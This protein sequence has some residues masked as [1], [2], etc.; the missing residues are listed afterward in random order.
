MSLE[1]TGDQQ[2]AISLHDRNLVVLAAAGS[3]KTFVLV[4]RYLALLEAHQDW[5]LE[6]LVAITFTRKAARELRERVRQELQRYAHAAD[7][8]QRKLWQTH[9]AS[10]ESAQISTIHGLCAKILRISAAEAGI[11]P[12]FD[13]LEADEAVIE[14]EKEIED[15]LQR[16]AASNDPSL[17]LFAEY[18]RTQI[19]AALR[20]QVA[21]HDLQQ[22]PEDLLQHWQQAWNA[23]VL[24]Q[25]DAL[26][27][28]AAF[29]DAVKWQRDH[30][31]PSG[32][33]LG[34]IWVTCRPLLYKLDDSPEPARALELMSEL[35]STIRLNVGSAKNWGGKE[36]LAEAKDVLRDLRV[37]VHLALAVTGDGIT[38]LDHRAA[39]LLPHWQRMI[40][41]VQDAFRARKRDAN[42]L[43]FND[44]ERLT[45]DVL[46]KP[47]VRDRFHR[48]F[49]QVLVDEF[50]DTSPLQW[51][52]IRA[53]ANPRDPG[54]LFVV[55]DPRQSI[56]AFRGADVRVFDEA[57]RQILDGGG[58]EISL[59]HSFR[60]HQPLLDLLNTTFSKVLQRASSGPAAQYEVEFGEALEAQRQAA[61]G[62]HPALELMLLDCKDAELNADDGHRLM[63]L[64]LGLRLRALV[65]QQTPVYDREIG[66]TR[67]LDYGDVALLFQT[68][69]SMPFYEDAF[70][71]LALPYVTVGGRGFYGRQ[72]VLDLLNLLRFLHN[73]ND[74]LALASVLRSPLFALSD[75]ALL[76][77]RLMRYE[78]DSRPPLWDALQQPQGLPGDE[79]PRARAASDCLR[80]LAQ[81][82]GRLSVDDLLRAA[83]ERTGYLATLTGL[84]DG[85]RRRG[86]VEK[87]VEK[88]AESG[89][90]HFTDFEAILGEFNARE[91]REGEAALEADGALT[92]MT[93]HQAKGLEFPMVVLADAGRW[94]TPTNDSVLMRD[95]ESGLACKVF[96]M[97]QGKHQPTVA[98]QLATR[99][100]QQRELAERRRLFYVAATRAQDYL[101]VCGLLEDN[102]P[103]QSWLAWLLKALEIEDLSASGTR[104]VGR[105]QAN[106]R[107]L[108]V[109]SVLEPGVEPPRPS[110]VER[111]NLAAQNDEGPPALLR[112]LPTYP[113]RA[114]QQLTV[115]SISRHYERVEG[116]K[117][118]N[119]G[120]DRSS[121]VLGDA[122]HE[123]LRWWRPDT[124]PDADSMR[125]R[126]RSTIRA[127]G[128][129]NPSEIESLAGKALDLL[130][131][132]ELSPLCALMKEARELFRELPFIYQRRDYLIDG[133]LDLLMQDAAGH[134]TLVDFKTAWL[135]GGASLTAAR[136]HAQRYHMQLGIY[137]EAVCQHPA[138][139]ASALTVQ[140]HYLQ[141]AL[142]VTVPAREWRHALSRLEEFAQ[143]ELQA[144]NRAD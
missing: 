52:I 44:L 12:D 130:D 60:A 79:V 14:L 81:L 100:K 136:E 87:L 35:S 140:V 138:V 91:L 17:S 107:F 98:W 77:L 1:R 93:V 95:E 2:R 69:S 86:N 99:R 135:G 41:L 115:T 8:P 90:L 62:P 57:R 38:D 109:P 11:D 108:A 65:E 34:D 113:A 7:A 64:S 131:R 66:T 96:D 71:E 89:A 15:V 46:E 13:V 111:E 94:R 27:E 24:A 137:A 143:L 49:H 141:Q 116:S 63:A 29:V 43:D 5:P 4:E 104:S 75:D 144:D 142:D 48:E 55:G 67:P 18:D 120:Q 9:L 72:E 6:S 30:S 84:P 45:C 114:P 73:H 125:Q 102:K 129:R 59:S 118:A 105:G 80:K 42:L 119:E 122:V 20:E 133:R 36:T 117:G 50:H 51:Q 56:Y 97:E 37:E 128:L 74:E 76:A 123:M 101:L 32:D 92:L 61:P 40:G 134:W 112:A 47:A 139:E 23:E 132:F 3:G 70:K 68:Y 121:R 22:L 19:M 83:L 39:R 21:Q 10:V 82:A 85:H 88:A 16:L 26:R 53:L 28:S 126:L 25:L 58:E 127:Q 124:Q 110:V 33:K 78:N 103:K 54:C 31:W 106:W